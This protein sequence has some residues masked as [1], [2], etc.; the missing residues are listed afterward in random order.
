ME[1][2]LTDRAAL[3]ERRTLFASLRR[4]LR[5]PRLLLMAVGLVVVL[6]SLPLLRTLALKENELDAMRVLDLLGREVLAA[7]AA[8]LSLGYALQEDKSLS[9]R[10]P[11]SHLLADGRL[12]LRQIGRAHV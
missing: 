3:P 6:V 12:V 1:G 11:D 4:T 5:G 7:E 10:L 8:P 9:R 2:T